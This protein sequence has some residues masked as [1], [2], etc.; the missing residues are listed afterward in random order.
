[1]RWLT[2]FVVTAEVHL[3]AW[4]P[5]WKRPQAYGGMGCLLWIAQNCEGC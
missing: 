4:Q 1:M 5:V 3:P 2:A